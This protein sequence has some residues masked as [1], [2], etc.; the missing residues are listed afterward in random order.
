VPHRQPRGCRPSPPQCSSTVLFTTKK[1]DAGT[2]G[3]DRRPASVGARGGWRST[4]AKAGCARTGETSS[5]AGVVASQKSNSR[6]AER[7]RR[8]PMAGR[9]CG[10]GCW[11]SSSD[12]PACTAC[13]T[14]QPAA[15]A[16]TMQASVARTMP[17]TGR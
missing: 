16:A 15:T 17:R 11:H 8:R 2:G 10:W 13:T 12:R 1:R 9:C 6:P 7:R 5:K 4:E 14:T 3:R